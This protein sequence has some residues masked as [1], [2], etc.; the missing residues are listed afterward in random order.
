MDGPAGQDLLLT[1][2]LAST[3]QSPERRPEAFLN[4]RGVG[5]LREQSEDHY[6]KRAY[7]SA[8]FAP[9][10]PIAA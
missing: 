10:V 9:A 2:G 7:I 5:L 3:W 4:P 6:G 8:V 1:D